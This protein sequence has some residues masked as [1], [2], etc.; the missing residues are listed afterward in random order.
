[1]WVVA[2]PF[3]GEISNEVGFQSSASSSLTTHQ[4]DPRYVVESKLLKSG[5]SY[6]I[7]RKTTCDL[8]VNH[9]K[10]SHDHGKFI[11]EGFS[12]DDVVR[13]LISPISWPC[14]LSMVTD[15]R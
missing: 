4:S 7:G 6:V 3:D 5:K 8:V 15:Q 14:L 13:I 9:K 12:P 2:G 10:V 1:M 11:V